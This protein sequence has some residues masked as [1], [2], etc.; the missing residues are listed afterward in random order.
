M[1]TE[2]AS[3][4]ADTT[5]ASTPQSAAAPE[6]SAAATGQAAEGANAQ[7][8]PEDAG[9]KVDGEK[10]ADA[11]IVYD[12]KAPEGVELD[13][14]AVERFKAVAGDL[15]MP[16]DQAQKVVDLYADL[17][18]A[19]TD[20]FVKQVETW[21]EETKADKEYGGDKLPET[22][23]SARKVIDTFGTPE[24]KSLLDSSG[25]GNH[26]EVVKLLAKVGKAISED[27]FIRGA[28]K[29]PAK[30]FYDNSNMN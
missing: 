28:P 12:F 9:A 2:A 17:R 10:P 23:A 30:S 8:K 27:G 18:K 13:A 21:G 20:A 24:F 25:M 14:S 11:P 3:A 29:G 22:L 7:A 19:E 1:T 16:A 26:P 15:K 6:A 5:E 4:G